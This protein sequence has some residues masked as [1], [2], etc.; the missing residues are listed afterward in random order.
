MNVLEVASLEKKYKEKHAVKDITFHLER[1]K[2][3]ALIGPNGAGKTTTLNMLAGLI[4]PTNG[5]ISTPDHAGDIRAMIGY[6]P[7]Y[8]S[9]F[10]WMSGMEYLIFSGEITGLTRKE[11][12][13]RSEELIK[14]V[15]LSEGQNRRINQ[16]SGGMKQRLGIAQALIHQPKLIILDEPVSALDPFGRREVLNLLNKLKEHTTILFSTHILNDAEQVCDDVLFLYNGELIE[17]GPLTDIKARHHSPSLKIHIEGDLGPY[18]EVLEELSWVR[19]LKVEKESMT[20]EVEKLNRDRSRLFTLI[21]EGDW[22]VAK[23]ESSDQSLEDLFMKVM[24]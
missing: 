15:N 13:H 16:Y 14:L 1:G 2:C 3:T 18:R 20:I 23:L 12:R 19:Q 24:R 9:Y 5:M 4:T 10:E 22:P 8:P 6:L 11:A 17:Q 7:Q 21:S